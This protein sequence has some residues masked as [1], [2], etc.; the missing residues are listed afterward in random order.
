M[1]AQMNGKSLRTFERARATRIRTCKYAGFGAYPALN[2]KLVRVLMRDASGGP[3]LLISH[4]H[5]IVASLHQ[6][7]RSRFSSGG[8]AGRASRS[9]VSATWTRKCVTGELWKSLHRIYI[10]PV[11]DRN[12]QSCD[13]VKRTELNDTLRI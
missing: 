12:V 1:R 13:F 5:S 8:D 6:D 4:A 7:E 10:H 3:L 9:R 2:S 11:G